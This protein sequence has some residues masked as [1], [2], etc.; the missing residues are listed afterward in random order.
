MKVGG[1]LFLVMLII[2]SLEV[3]ELKAAVR[4]L[5]LLG[6][7]IN[8]CSGDWDCDPEERCV[9]NGCGHICVPV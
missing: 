9:S 3:Q 1:F 5:Q 6:D 7:C 4:P 8:L 2:L